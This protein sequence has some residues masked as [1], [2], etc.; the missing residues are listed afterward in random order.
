MR[1]TD[2]FQVFSICAI[3]RVQAKKMYIKRMLFYVKSNTV[4]DKM[5]VYK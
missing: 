2:Q 1:I 5:L 3:T 4:V